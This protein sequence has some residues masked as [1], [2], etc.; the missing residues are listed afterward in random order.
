MP[1]GLTF[2]PVT[3]LISGTPTTDGSFAVTLTV[4]DGSFTASS[5]LQLTFTSDP[6][7]PVITSPSE[8]SVVPGQSFF[9]QIVAPA[10]DPND[11]VTYTLLGTLP[12]GLGFDAA[13]GTISGTP[14]LR[15]HYAGK[16][17][18][19][20][21]GVITNVQIFATN[22]KGTATKPLAILPCADWCGEHRHAPGHRH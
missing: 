18:P 17:K 13:T 4:T 3:G 20:S 15:A 21:G 12:P 10:S 9:Y 5:T 16:G 7:V 6:A 14:T 1:A 11:P 19:L 8:A 22:S 2:D